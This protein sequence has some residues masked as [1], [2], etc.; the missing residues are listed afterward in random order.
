MFNFFF[1]SVDEQHKWGKNSGIWQIW[2]LWLLPTIAVTTL[3]I[4]SWSNT[5]LHWTIHNRERLG[6]KRPFTGMRT[7][8]Q[9]A[10]NSIHQFIIF[11]CS[12]NATLNKASK[13]WLYYQ[14]H[15]E[16]ESSFCVY[17]LSNLPFYQEASG[18]HRHL[19]TEQGR[20][21][22]DQTFPVFVLHISLRALFCFICLLSKSDMRVR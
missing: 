19:K 17:S 10:K 15:T 7:Y 20:V 18:Q 21:K 4:E 2:C 3:E 8:L 16:M 6:Y 14:Q 22:N 1:F 11:I 9:I 5:A 12:T 13:K